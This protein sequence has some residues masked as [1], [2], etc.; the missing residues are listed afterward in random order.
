MNDW[1]DSSDDEEFVPG[2]E[3]DDDV[4][5]MDF[6]LFNLQ[7]FFSSDSIDAT[8]IHNRFFAPLNCGLDSGIHSSYFYFIFF[9][10]FN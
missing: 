3:E 2:R 9:F 6:I 8:Y 10:F 1:G 7:F 5:S 4:S